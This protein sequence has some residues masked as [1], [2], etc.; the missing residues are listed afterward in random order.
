MIVMRLNSRAA[1]SGCEAI[2]AIAQS[3]PV[4]IAGAVAWSAHP[5]LIR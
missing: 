2:A 5:K 1:D 4:A 3:S